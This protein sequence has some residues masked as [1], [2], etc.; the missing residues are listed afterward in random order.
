MLDTSQNPACPSW[1]TE[2]GDLRLFALGVKKHADSL[3]SFEGYWEFWVISLCDP[4]SFFFLR[5][6][7]SPTQCFLSACASDLSAFTF[8]FS[9]M[10]PIPSVLDLR[11]HPRCVSLFHSWTSSTPNSLSHLLILM[12]PPGP[13]GFKLPT[14][15]LM[16]VGQK[17]K[18][19]G[20]HPKTGNEKF[21][22]VRMHSTSVC[23]TISISEEVR[24]E[25]SFLSKGKG[26]NGKE[27]KTAKFSAWVQASD[28]ASFFQC[29]LGL[30]LWKKAT[31]VYGSIKK[32]PAT[33][34][35]PCLVIYAH[36]GKHC[37]VYLPPLPGSVC[38][39]PT[40][41]STPYWLW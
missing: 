27:R 34:H 21:M 16:C 25:I 38:P 12:L 31:S 40:L 18:G 22:P 10:F 32:H 6:P 5:L 33:S 14:F 8:S 36:S 3:S 39:G 13:L 28:E 35:S 37:P 24:K 29:D 4:C 20:T 9:H 2:L 19:W 30:V 7:P 26:R 41:A 1:N 17:N 15:S 23:L 11:F